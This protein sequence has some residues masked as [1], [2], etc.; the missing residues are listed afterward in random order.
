VST[1][2][3]ILLGTALAGPY[4]DSESARSGS[5]SQRLAPQDNADLVLFYTSEQ[6]GRLGTC[7]CA[8][9]PRG[10]LGRIASYV[11]ASD[12]K[13]HTPSLLLHAGAWASDRIDQTGALRGDTEIANQHM[14]KGLEQLGFDTVNIGWRDS[15]WFANHPVPDWAVSATIRPEAGPAA[16]YRVT[17]VGSLRVAVIGASRWTVDWLQ[18]KGWHGI[19]ALDAVTA[20][21]PEV[22]EQSDL[23]VVLAF[24]TGRETQRIAQ[25]EGVDVVIEAGGYVGRDAPWA[26][27]HSVWVRSRNEG[28][29][30]GEL[31]LWLND[32][33]GIE[34]G[35]DRW[36][37]LDE[38]IPEAGHQKALG[39]RSD[40]AQTRWLKQH[41][42]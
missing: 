17:E 20:L 2:A 25:L 32:S 30:I 9:R 12:R 28:Q 15:P 1:L 4:M 42:R 11:A 22:V 19:D 27:D 21:L 18:P 23:V 40:K 34:H 36:I 31:R 5:L 29:S 7:G 3:A 16:G 26:G 35:L 8:Q 33:G 37:D 10:G 6:G 14:A 39:K 13:Q 41:L 24:E 38:R